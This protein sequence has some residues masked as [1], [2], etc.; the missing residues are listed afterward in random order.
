MAHDHQFV[1]HDNGYVSGQGVH[2]NQTECLWSLDICY[3]TNIA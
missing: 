2:T 1:V 3:W